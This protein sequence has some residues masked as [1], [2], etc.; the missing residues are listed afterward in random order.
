MAKAT[1]PPRS[2]TLLSEERATALET[3]VSLISLFA[4]VAARVAKR[5]ADEAFTLAEPAKDRLLTSAQRYW[6]KAQSPAVPAKSTVMVWPLPSR[7]MF[8][9][10]MM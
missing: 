5:A 8:Q 7:G 2:V 3:L 9:Y 1:R 6:K 10:L 4:N